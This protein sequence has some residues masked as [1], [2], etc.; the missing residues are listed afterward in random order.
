MLKT[1]HKVSLAS[2]WSLCIVSRSLSV[3]VTHLRS[4][5][6][7]NVSDSHRKLSAGYNVSDSH[8]KLSEGYN[9]SDSHRKLSAGY[10][11]SDSHRKLS[12]G[13][14]VSDSHRKLQE[15]I[16]ELRE[17]LIRET[18]L[19]FNHSTRSITAL[20]LIHARFDHV[21]LTKFSLVV[22]GTSGRESRN[23][24]RERTVNPQTRLEV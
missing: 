2:I 18:L 16:E 10:N 7:Y 13:Y 20:A 11:V 22:S 1:I 21:I 24:V 3:T 17:D 4:S 14:N 19:L 5:A 8:R 15:V 6:G 23:R 12:A 9:V